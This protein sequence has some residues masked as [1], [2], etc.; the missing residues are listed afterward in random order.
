[1][2]REMDSIWLIDEKSTHNNIIKIWQEI[3]YIHKHCLDNFI[4]KKYMNNQN[5]YRMCSILKIPL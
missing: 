3:S 1:M 4:S 2:K 5:R